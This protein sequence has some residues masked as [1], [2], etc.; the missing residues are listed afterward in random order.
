[1]LTR[2]RLGGCSRVRRR[3]LGLR[4]WVGRGRWRGRVGGL[5]LRLW[6]VVGGNG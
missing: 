6:P 3:R 5:G 2:L 4:R 1:M